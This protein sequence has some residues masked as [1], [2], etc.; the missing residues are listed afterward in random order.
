MKVVIIY[1]S[2]WAS[3]SCDLLLSVHFSLDNN[4]LLYVTKL[5]IYF[6]PLGMR[7]YWFGLTEAA[8]KDPVNTKFLLDLYENNKVKRTKHNYCGAFKTWCKYCFDI[9]ENPFYIPFK[10]PFVINWL[11]SRVRNSNSC[12][13]FRTAIS[14]LAWYEKCAHG[15]PELWLQNPGFKDFRK[16]INKQYV[17]KVTTIA[18]CTFP[19]H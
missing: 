16:M 6:V 2:L 4:C 11:C 10:L 13:T 14:A 8:R 3:C 18:F 12:S 1:F 5:H 19:K 17:F 9:G 15:N 7:R